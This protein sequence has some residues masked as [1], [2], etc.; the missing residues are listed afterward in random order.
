MIHV[1]AA[2]GKN[3]RNAAV[4]RISIKP[5]KGKVNKSGVD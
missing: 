1:H 5:G 2:A 3:I 4:L